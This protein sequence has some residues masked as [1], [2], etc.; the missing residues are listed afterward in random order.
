MFFTDAKDYDG[1]VL[2]D[3][4]DENVNTLV[5]VALNNPN[6]DIGAVTLSA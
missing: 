5:R 2:I 1:K 6:I 3:D 4:L